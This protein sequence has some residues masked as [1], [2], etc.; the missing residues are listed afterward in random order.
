MSRPY[1]PLA[2]PQ[3]EAVID[4]LYEQ[5][6]GQTGALL[7]Y[8]LPQLPRLLLGGRIDWS[9]DAGFYRDKFLPLDRDQAELLYVLARAVGAQRVVEFGTSYGLSTI[10]LAA[11]VRDNTQGAGAA[12]LVIGSEME[13]GKCV[14]ARRH[15]EE[16]G[17][18]PYADVREGNA[19]HTLHYVGNPV[20][21]LLLDGWANLNLLVLQLLMPALRPGAL[22]VADNA[23]GPFKA[24]MG[25][26]LAFLRDPANGFRMTVLGLKS[27]MAIAVKT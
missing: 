15:L 22:V 4:R 16:A 14:A 7:W 10:F 1:S 18:A 13:P 23:G 5:S 21:L 8:Y 19:L 17:L 9:R 26:C 6:R 12:G 25:P 2:D 20:D 27:G 3:A 11:A 24:D